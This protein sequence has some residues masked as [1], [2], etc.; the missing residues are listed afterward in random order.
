MSKISKAYEYWSSDEY[1]DEESRIELLN[2]K[3]EGEI[4][5]RFYKELSFGTSGMRGIMGIGTNR[6]NKY[7][8]RR[9]AYG[10]SVEIVQ[11]GKEACQRGVAI[12]YDSRN[13]SAEFA[14]ETAL[15]LANHGIKSFLF[16]DIRS[17]PELSFVVRYKKC[18]AGVNI[19]ASH[20]PKEY[21]GFKVYWEDGSQISVEF[22]DKILSN[23]S[24]C[25]DYKVDIV[26][27]EEARSNHL[28][29]F[30]GED[31][32]SAYLQVLKSTAY[33]DELCKD[34]GKELSILYTPLHGVGASTIERLL[35]E[36]GFLNLFTVPEQREPDGEFPTIRY[37]NPEVPQAFDWALKYAK[38]REPDIVIATDPDADRLGLYARD[39]EGDFIR[40]S[41]NQ[42]GAILLQY[43]CEIREKQGNLPSDGIVIK[44]LPTSGV[45]EKIA[46]KF[47]QT[48]I[49]IPVGFK[50]IGEQM[51]LMGESV[52]SKFIFGVEESHGYLAGTYTREKDAVGAVL[53]LAEAALYY[54]TIHCKNL[55]Q[56]LDDVYASVGYFVDEQVSFSFQGQ[57]GAQKMND[58]MEEISTREY[59]DI[60]GIPVVSTED[61]RS[62]VKK[63]FDERTPQ[64]LLF[65]STNMY[66]IILES[67][68]IVIRPSGTEP[69]IKFYFSL[70]GTSHEKILEIIENLKKE[71]FAS[72]ANLT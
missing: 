19:T 47:N 58:I 48:L 39:N 13:N 71:F 37:P 55:V 62:C 57:E 32:D 16:D 23:M 67:G 22:A 42:I 44:S 64:K 29:V 26:T 33:L 60:G 10:L 35:E 40:F 5:D 38:E 50:Y 65:D 34:R 17:T 30:I 52:D 25:E 3:E 14:L 66:K 36:T 24:K 70:S 2:I 28:I 56:V 12:A 9:A 45:I 51:E 15:V 31:C 69:K 20:N 4:S 49:N 61:Y 11:N 1:F 46:H 6:I 21:N 53:L 8:I 63:F 43:L 72:I 59:L 7:T 18:I 54:K 41:G 68:S 27:E